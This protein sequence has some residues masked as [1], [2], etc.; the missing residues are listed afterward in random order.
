[1]TVC[2]RR[3]QL[4]F[5]TI[6]GVAK[7]TITENPLSKPSRMNEKMAMPSDTIGT[8]DAAR[9]LGYDEQPIRPFV[10]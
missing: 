2:F 1:M 9:I 6:A 4:G 5:V 7:A 3:M 8:A 10:I